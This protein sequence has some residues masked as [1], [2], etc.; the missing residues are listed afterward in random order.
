MWPLLKSDCPLS[1]S[2][3]GYTDSQGISAPEEGAHKHSVWL[4]LTG[5]REGIPASLTHLRVWGQRHRV[6]Y[7]KPH[8]G[9]SRYVCLLPGVLPFSPAG[10]WT[11]SHPW[12]IALNW[13]I[14]AFQI[15]RSS[16]P[17]AVIKSSCG[18]I[19]G[20]VVCF[21]RAWGKCPAIQLATAKAACTPGLI[22]CLGRK[23]SG[24]GV[25]SSQWAC[26]FQHEDICSQCGPMA[27]WN[28]FVCL[29]MSTGRSY[30]LARNRDVQLRRPH[31][32]T[33]LRL[34]WEV[35]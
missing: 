24:S 4:P 2:C 28:C 7:P 21:P 35:T 16:S 3:P 1:P 10:P 18:K 17:T 31:E 23:R 32:D 20:H 34:G 29:E 9:T 12:E 5:V 8:R 27:P 14:D 33:D 15:N 25:P 13:E 26:L 22:L 6:S 30:K 19:E 11:Q